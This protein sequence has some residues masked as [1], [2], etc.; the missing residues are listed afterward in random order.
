MAVNDG[1]RKVRPTCLY[2]TDRK[3]A[4]RYLIDTGA[5]ISVMPASFSEKKN[6]SSALCLYSASG[7]PI[8]TF[9]T[10]LVEVNLGLNRH[11]TWP[12]I[13]AAVTSP[14]LG[15][16][17]LHHYNLMVDLKHERL[18]DGVTGLTTNG[19]LA[20]LP[21][22]GSL[23]TT[24]IN[25]KYRDLLESFPK[26]FSPSLTVPDDLP[27]YH[28][29]V[30]SGPPV[31]A[32][33]R[34]LPPDKL[35]D[36][37]LQFQ[38]MCAQGICR[39]SKS[40]WAS[41][42]HMVKKQDGSWRPCGDYRALNNVTTPDRYPIPNLLDFNAELTGK[43]I[44]SK[45]DLVKA[46]YNIPVA[47]ED[48][49]KTA[50]I[51]PFGLFEFLRMPFG[52][53]NAAQTFQRFIHHI[54]RD[55]PWAFP[56]IDDILIASSDENEHR[57]H[58]SMLF[59]VLSSYGLTINVEK[60]DLGKEN[61]DFLGY[62]VNA[63]GIRPQADRVQAIVDY[64]KP[65]DVKG[66]QRFLGMVNFYHRCLPKAAPT[67]D[68][69]YSLIPNGRKND[70]IVW[71]PEADVSFQKVK[72]SLCQAALLAHP[73]PHSPLIL[74]TDASLTSIGASLQ[75]KQNNNVVPL[76]FFSR[77]LTP[78]QQKYSTYDRELLAIYSAI[79]YFRPYLEGRI[80]S[81]WTDHLPLTTA[82][83]QNLDKASPRQQR[84]LDFISQ[85]STDICYIPGIENNVADALSRVSAIDFTD[86]DSLVKIAESQ[87]TDTE[88][89]QLLKSNP[90]FMKL[91]PSPIL[92]TNRTILCDTLSTTHR[93]YLPP[94]FRRQAFED[95]HNQAHPGIRATTKLVTARY[96]WPS[97]RKDVRQWTRCCQACQRSKVTRHNVTPLH[98]F[99]LPAA[100]F[101]DL[102][103]DIVGPLPP[104]N[105]FR[106]ILTII[107]RYSRWVEALPIADITA[108]T[109]SESFHREWISRY[110]VPSTVVT[111]QGRQFESEF[112]KELG[113][114]MGFARNRTTAYHP[115]SNGMIERFHRTLKSSLMATL[116]GQSHWSRILP[117]VLL[118]LR[119][120]IRED[121]NASSS[122]LVFGQSLRLP[123]D[124]FQPTTSSPSEEEY[125][126]QL[127]NAMAQCTPTP[128]RLNLK[129]R[130]F[131][132]RHLS[133]SSHVFLRIDS[134]RPPLTPPYA[135][136]YQLLD[137]DEKTCKIE[138][139]GKPTLVSI[140]RVK[141]CHLLRESTNSTDP[142]APV[143]RPDSDASPPSTTTTRSGRRVHFPARFLS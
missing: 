98:R 139:N 114:I 2:L 37:K 28:S 50:V 93:P 72:D 13:I 80:F 1:R 24:P 8:S 96:V 85:F 110:G 124:F 48:I 83:N 81:I 7:S 137:L 108:S 63:T 45:I 94:E 128:P 75:Q 79:K 109:V 126:K 33:A 59:K 68:V 18:V 132:D 136:P 115:Q 53:R 30:T 103:M 84:H 9:G 55:F 58:L 15:A 51:T 61:L 4:V 35:S 47:E 32:K 25:I 135:G 71:T 11:F 116:Q 82:F 64:P 134:V 140:D 14:I 86:T 117:T 123:G 57:A 125:L 38:T 44:F 70:T 66:L 95:V 41:P 106:Y 5:A 65:K 102:H 60:C 118:G 127:R 143:R 73:D 105:G 92:G 36:A 27:V 69:L 42:L 67:Q 62:T 56:Y 89:Q 12:F 74:A 26:L 87:Q 141:P 122:D 104:S 3:S 6:S 39:P 20:R 107:D 54:L 119:T 76:A 90:S 49:M 120:A 101:Q 131:V 91:E 34:R 97:I 99:P 16:D 113:R 78:A 10:K 112:F 43:K 111:D 77:K 142:S 130:P 19:S 23:R 40:P 133:N 121:I 88:L 22:I 29:I 46:F 31:F 21:T 100:K 52:L 129:H 17:F 138:I